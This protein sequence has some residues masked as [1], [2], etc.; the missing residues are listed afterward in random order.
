MW[1]GIDKIRKSGEQDGC[2]SERHGTREKKQIILIYVCKYMGWMPKRNCVIQVNI[3][4]VMK[5]KGS[6]GDGVKVVITTEKWRKSAQRAR[7]PNLGREAHA[8]THTEAKRTERVSRYVHVCARVYDKIQFSQSKRWIYFSYRIFIHSFYFRLY[9][10]SLGA[11]W[12]H[13]HWIFF[14]LVL[15]ARAHEKERE[16]TNVDLRLSTDANRKCVFSHTLALRRIY[17]RTHKY[18]HAKNC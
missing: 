16:K 7:K 14:S 10:F 12:I 6:S 1:S 3:S 5:V 17:V 9:F 2:V 8:H 11:Q 15:L 13:A 18:T 4:A